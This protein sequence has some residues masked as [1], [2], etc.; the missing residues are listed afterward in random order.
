MDS[1]FLFAP[2]GPQHAPAAL[3]PGVTNLIN[4]ISEL[5]GNVEPRPRSGSTLAG[6]KNKSRLMQPASFRRDWK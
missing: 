4:P 1:L 5:D 6:Q 3:V 2:A